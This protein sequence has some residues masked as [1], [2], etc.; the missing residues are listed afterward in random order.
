M[1]KKQ[2]A[3]IRINIYNTKIWDTK[4]KKRNKKN[5]INKICKLQPI[6]APNF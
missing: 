4:I 2:I 3:Q 1:Y 6:K 5:K